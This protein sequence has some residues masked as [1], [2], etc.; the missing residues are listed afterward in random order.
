MRGVVGISKFASAAV[1]LLAC[2]SLQLPVTAV[3]APKLTT[4]HSF[5][6]SSD[7]ANPWSRLLMGPDGVLYGTTFFGGKFN[8]GVVF[9]LTPPLAG[10]RRWREKVLHHFRGLGTGA[11]PG[12]GLTK[13][14]NGVLYGTTVAI[15]YTA[16]NVGTVFSLTPPPPGETQW[17]KRVLYV[18]TDPGDGFLTG[19][20][21]RGPGGVL[22]GGTSHGGASDSGT[23]FML[24]PRP[25]GL[26][27][28]EILYSFTGSPDGKHFAGVM[29]QD[30]DGALYGTTMDGGPARFCGIVF[31]LIPPAPGH[32]RWREQILHGFP[33]PPSPCDPDSGV[34]LAPDGSLYG[35][36]FIGG[37]F[38]QIGE[39]AVFKLSPPAPGKTQWKHTRLHSFGGGSDGRRPQGSVVKGS[40][41]ALY[42]TTWLGGASNAGTIFRLT[43]PLPGSEQWKED[44]LHHFTG[45]SDG[46]QPE[47]V[48]I[49]GGDG[50][51]YGTTKDGGAFGKGTVY[52]LAQ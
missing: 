25:E 16:E 20:L 34:I 46:G 7:G 18:F 5:S 28:K 41:G 31:K 8:K 22:Y 27:K 23:V 4:L 15:N 3:A 33:A 36:T 37:E 49:R 32:R 38:G 1:W 9:S 14:P 21:T 2:A 12:S 17:S 47:T 40:G 39:G 45:G 24:T 48:P 10:D 50:A 43:P 19:G 52:K 11:N 51:L 29:V 30:S 26:W 6:G 44:V 35:T 42:G 13:G